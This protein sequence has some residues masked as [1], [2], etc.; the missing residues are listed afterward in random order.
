MTPVRTNH[1][2]RP[3]TVVS[4]TPALAEQGEASAPAPAPAPPEGRIR[5]GRLAGLSMPRAIWVISWPILVQSVLTWLVGL[6]DTVL[7]AGISEPAT[8]AIGGATYVMWFVALVVTAIGVGATALISRAV[9]SGRLA[10]ADAALGQTVLLAVV[11]GLVTGGLVAGAATPLAGMMSMGEE[12]RRAFT[13]YL[14]ITAFGVPVQAVLFVGIECARAAGDSRRP[15]RAMVLVNVVN[16]VASWVLAGVDLTTTSVREG[17]AVTRTVL[18][19]PFGFEWG[20]A[21]IAVGTVLAEVAGLVMV[22]R[23]LASGRTGLR[24]RRRRLAPHWHTLRRLV[25]VGLPNFLETLGMW[26]GNFL[27][28]LM[29]GWLAAEQSRAGH[30]QGLLGAHVVAIRIEA[31]SFLPGF[32]M[33]TAAAALAGQYLGAGSPRLATRAILACLAVSAGF[34]GVAG[35]LLVLVPVTIT[36]LLTSQPAHLELVPKLIF[37]AGIVQVPF[38]VSLVLRTA[39]RGAGDVK[40]VMWLTWLTT[41][42]VRLPLAYLGSG[43]DIPLPGGGV[44]PNPMPWDG[45]LP[46]LWVGLCAE[47][48]VRAVAFGARFLQGGWTTVRV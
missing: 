20:V 12:A 46:G 13:V 22:L 30:P 21:G 31:M 36:G 45:G 39:L 15:L 35:L 5:A 47:I 1:P 37:I 11:A 43:V 17:V 4:G 32:A 2:A 29:V 44:I 34:M 41:Y 40:V 7:A 27:I 48:V 38:A 28:V 24:L 18:E 10:V 26:A 42:G 3:D 8:D 9:G 33:G 25:R 6:T 19:N 16:I 14:L 23:L